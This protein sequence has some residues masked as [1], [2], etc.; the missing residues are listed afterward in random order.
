MQTIYGVDF[1]G[2][3]LA[4]RNIWVARLEKP[5]DS[6]QGRA[7]LT[8]VDALETL[9]GTAEREPALR[10]LVN[11]IQASQNTL[12]AIDFPFGLP[13]EI[14]DPPARWPDLLERVEAWPDGANAFGHWCLA[15]AKSLGLANHVRRTTDVEQRTPFD[16]Y[17]Y[18]IIYQTFHGIRDVLRPLSTDPATAVLPFQYEKLPAAGRAVIEACPSSTLKRL[19]LPH[20]NYKQPAG[21]PL[22]RRRLATRKILLAALDERLD[23]PPP[24]RRRIAR[25]PGGD[26]M[27]AV[28]AALGA[29]QAWQ[30]VDHAAIA[31]DARYP[32]EGYIYA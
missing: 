7:T 1:S 12:W 28:L 4:G 29:W 8:H 30:T 22:T 15:R 3:K 19:G 27:D 25:N 26:A 20:Q 18:R 2:A 17:H 11:F 10:H 9:A 16:C 32:R 24:L 23:I 21:G 5:R 13:V 14:L 6:T 31:A